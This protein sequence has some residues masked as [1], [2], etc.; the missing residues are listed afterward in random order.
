ME[1]SKQKQAYEAIKRKIIVGEYLP[2]SDLSEEKLQMELQLSRTPIREAILKLHEE[3]FLQVYP[4]KGTIVTDISMEMVHQ[5]YEIRLLN[6]PHIVA[7]ACGKLQ[8]E[9]LQSV[10][11]IFDGYTEEAWAADPMQ[12]INK[13]QEVHSRT[14][15]TCHNPFL[16]SMMEKVYDHSH[17]LRIRV[18]SVNPQYRQSVG[19]HSEIIKALLK[20]DPK[21]AREAAVKH[22][23]TASKE[24]MR[25]YWL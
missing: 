5:L 16:R 17:R 13:D 11:E 14:L 12:Y 20:N 7:N 23:Q 25:F 18:S 2:L 4:R 8:E 9:W 3:G 24:A 15:Q 21:A 10:L 6:E 1:T 22:I 19:E